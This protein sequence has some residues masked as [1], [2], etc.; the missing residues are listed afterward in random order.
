MFLVGRWKTRSRWT[1]GS[2]PKRVYAEFGINRN[3]DRIPRIVNMAGT[4]KKLMLLVLWRIGIMAWRDGVLTPDLAV[5]AFGSQLATALVLE[6]AV[7][8]V[9]SFFLGIVDT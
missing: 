1:R 8:S 9:G 4:A 2:A 7:G 5:Y 6:H 3:V